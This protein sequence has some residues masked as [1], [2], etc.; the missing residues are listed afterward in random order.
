MNDPKSLDD[1][2]GP[3]TAR[4]LEAM[5]LEDV[6]AELVGGDLVCE[7]PAGFHHGVLASTIGRHLWDFVHARHLGRVLGAETGFILARDPDTVRAPD[8]AFVAGERLTGPLPVG[9]F[10]G[11]PDLAVEVFSPGDSG[12]AV[13]GKVRDYLAAGTRQVWVVDGRSET[14]TVHRPRRSPVT[15]TGADSL[16]GDDVLPGFSLPVAAFFES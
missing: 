5:Y 12:P 4:D 13:L 2:A 1:R 7:P 15:L 3:L 6:R 8:A 16:K 11:A 9:F 10:E 14:V